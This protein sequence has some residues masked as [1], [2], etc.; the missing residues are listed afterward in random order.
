MAIN[1]FGIFGPR[2]SDAEIS[3]NISN[4]LGRASTNAK[5]G[6]ASALNPIYGVEVPQTGAPDLTNRMLQIMSGQLGGT[7]SGGEKLSALGALLK[8]VSR[9]SQTSPQQVLQSIQQQKLGE[10]QGALQIQELRKAAAEKAQTDALKAEYVGQAAQTNPQLA[11]AIALMSPEKFADFII[12]QNKPEGPGQWSE[13]LGRF[14]PRNRPVV[15]GSGDYTDAPGA[16][17]KQ[18]SDGTTVV[19]YKD[20]TSVTFDEEGNEVN[21]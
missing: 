14:I 10:V 8:S 9:G 3:Q 18:F 13:K 2:G 11:R 19:T 7:L 5:I 12:Q 1:P 21:G 16:K 20:G 4:V 6:A 15:T 17:Y